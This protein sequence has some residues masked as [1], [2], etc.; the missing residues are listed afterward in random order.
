MKKKL[1]SMALAICLAFGSAAA[2][3][4]GTFEGSTSITAS[5]L[6]SGDY[7]YSTL[8]DGTVSITKYNGSASRLTI[9]STLAGKKVTGIGYQAFISCASLKNVTIPNSVTYIG[10][11]AFYKCSNLTSV[12]IPNSVKSL[13]SYAFWNCTSLASITIPGSVE[14]INEDTFAG[15]T[16]LKTATINKGVKKIDY[17]AFEGCTSLKT[18]SIPNS[19]KDIYTDAFRNCSSLT[20]VT[21]PGSVKTIGGFV[22][23]GCSNL[24]SATISNGVEKLAAGVFEDCKSMTSVSIANSVKEIGYD[25]FKGCESL[26]SVTIPKAVTY[27]DSGTFRDCKSLTSVTIPDGVEGIGGH[28]FSDCTN[29]TS[30][31]IPTTVKAIY[32]EA[33]WGCTKLKTVAIPSNV[34]YIQSRAFGYADYK[35]IDGFKIYCYKGS[36]GETYAKDSGLAYEYINRLAGE[37][38]YGTAADISETMYTSKKT[39]TVVLA[40]GLDSADALAG[41]PLASKLNAPILLTTKDKLPD[42]TLAEIKRL[43]A[44]KVYILGGTGAISEKVVSTLKSNGISA[45]NIKRLAGASRYGTATAIADAINTK[46]TEIFF[47]NGMKYAD[48]LSASAPAAVKGAPIIY[49]PEKGTI[50]KDTAAYLKKIKGSVKNA[51]VIG[52]TGVISAD[53]MKQAATALGLTVDKTIVRISGSDRYATCV[54]VNNKFKSVLTGKDICLAKGLDFPDALA[55]GVFA[56]QNKAPLF[57]VDNKL[58]D[59]QKTY[60]KSKKASNIYVIGGTGAVPDYLVAA[61]GEASA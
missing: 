57:L 12:T 30:V 35:K 46:P 6:T 7:E 45:S 48:A 40:Y 39:D 31:S 26:K 4:Q 15:C 56:A 24:K 34:T 22:F 33:F 3:P 55:G 1:L 61:V 50:D 28:A 8:T 23:K 44:K 16:A 60:L 38:R 59:V 36:A 9:P 58:Q 11:Y 5:A 20:T 54:A 19:V 53:V 43:G 52:G 51:Y 27:I 32:S 2:L 47:V 49:L 41:V 14:S 29:L 13:G 21:V 37:N 10:G 25:V 18:V 42:D 17:S